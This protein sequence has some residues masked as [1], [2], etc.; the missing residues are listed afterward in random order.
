M[1]TEEWKNKLYFGDNLTILRDHVDDESV[2]L[3]YLDPPFN[4]R[5]TYNVLFRE[6]N[7]TESAAQITAFEDTWHW[8][9]ESEAAYLEVVTAGGKLADLLGA[10]RQFLGTN[11][12]MAYLTMMAVRLRELHRVLKPTGSLYLHCDPTASHYLKLLLDAVFGA[13]SF[14]NEITWVRSLPHNDSQRFGRSRDTVFFYSKTDEMVFN[15]QYR[16]QKARSVKAHYRPDSSGR[17]FRLAS[18]L[19]PG[20]RGPRYEYKGYERNWRFT[21]ENMAKLESE[22]RVWHE[23][24][25]MPSRILFLDES[26]GAAV[27]DHWDDIGPINAQARERLGFP[28][29]KPEALLERII[30]ASS[31][32]GDVVLDPFCGCGTALAVAERLHRKWIGIDITHLAIALMKHRLHDTFADELSPY[33]VVGDPKDLGGARA[34]A[35]E[36]RYQ[37]EWW[38]LGLVEAQP[39]QDK[40]KGA[41]KG[42]DGLIYFVDNAAGRLRRV[43]VQVK[44]GHVQRAQVSDLCHAL[45]RENAAIGLFITL[46]KPTRPMLEEAATAGFYEAEELGK[47]YPRLQVLT[48]EELL[49]GKQAQYPRGAGRLTFQRAKRR[50]KKRREQPSLLDVH[51]EV[52]GN[53]ETRRGG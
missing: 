27:Q 36:D 19:A 52:N 7:G 16:P 20:G 47:K 45:E 15:P 13:K 8:G 24:G 6:K 11:D 2:D 1:T 30:E 32:E 43:L 25:K 49:D 50:G 48:V 31:N 44:S 42:I 33:E 14:R 29:Q 4:S 34:L 46:E 5:A 18:L 12:M 53:A 28:T 10:L 41:D 23:P 35:E 38:A 17:M 21:Q 26:M 9:M 51:R 37:F 22:G 39:A 40:K 3:V